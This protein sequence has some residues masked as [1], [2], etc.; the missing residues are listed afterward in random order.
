ML[1]LAGHIA[2]GFHPETLREDISNKIQTLLYAILNNLIQEI[3]RNSF[4]WPMTSTRFRTSSWRPAKFSSEAFTSLVHRFLHPRAVNPPSLWW[5]LHS[6]GDLNFGFDC[7]VQLRIVGTSRFAKFWSCLNACSTICQ[8]KENLRG[9]RVVDPLSKKRA[10][11]V[12]GTGGQELLGQVAFIL[13]MPFQWSLEPFMM[14]RV[15][16]GGDVFLLFG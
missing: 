12:Y 3:Y 9:V 16:Y 7:C 13:V 4:A 10:V 11:L 6:H 2:R 14:L 5:W 1:S 15:G 8:R